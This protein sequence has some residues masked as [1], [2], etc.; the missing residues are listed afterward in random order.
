MRVDKQTIPFAAVAT[1]GALAEFD[2][3]G[4]KRFSVVV[5]ITAHGGTATNT[6]VDMVP[7]SA[8]AGTLFT[9]ADY[10]GHAADLTNTTGFFALNRY[11]AVGVAKTGILPFDLVSIPV[12]FNFQRVRCTLV[13]AGHTITGNVHIYR[14]FE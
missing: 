9:N 8:M 14:V 11:G 12:N 10:I 6:F 7:I 2:L 5:E 1:L 13:G 4:A 3:Q